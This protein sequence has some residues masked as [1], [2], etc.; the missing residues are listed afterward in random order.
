MSECIFCQIADGSL[1]SEK[2]FEDEEKYVIKDIKPQAPVHLLI[3]PKKHL[4]TLADAK[5]SDEDLFGRLLGVAQ[6]QAVEQGVADSGY[7]VVINCRNDGGQVVPHLH[8][9]LLGGRQ[10]G[11]M[12]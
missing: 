3:I 11:D 10:L 4:P 6:K 8:V 7:R 9:H 5:E 2:I 12:A 1:P